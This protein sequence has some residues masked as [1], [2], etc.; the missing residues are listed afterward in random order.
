MTVEAEDA[1]DALHEAAAAIGGR[2]GFRPPDAAIILGTG[3]GQAAREIRDPVVIPYLEIPHFPPATAETHEGRLL[4]GELGGARVAALQGRYHR[5][6]G[7]DLGSVTFAVR[8]LGL[9][10]ARLLIVSNASGGLNPLWRAGDVALIEDHLNL[11]GENPLA[12]PNLE[13]LGPRFP[14]MSAPYDAELRALASAIAREAGFPLPS[15][16]Y[17]VVAGPNLETRAEYR[18][19]RALGAD[20]VGMSTV[21]EVIVA[22]HMGMRVLGLS[23]ITDECRPDALEPV[24]IDTIIRTARAAEPQLTLLITEVLKRWRGGGSKDA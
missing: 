2:A 8:V 24:D 23:I 11:L 16:V 3:L 17:A 21:P 22:R 19:L 4:L 20:M 1:S 9:L 18:M 15:G 12:G 5:Y 7:Y 10:G 13:D 14:N 6:E